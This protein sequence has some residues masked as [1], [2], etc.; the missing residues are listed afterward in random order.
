MN[1]NNTILD[2]IITIGKVG[3]V[4]IA[5]YFSK[6]YVQRSRKND[7]TKAGIIEKLV[8]YISAL[9]IIA[10]CSWAI[11]EFEGFNL[12]IF[13]I[14]SVAS[15]YGLFIEFGKDARLT[16]EQRLKRNMQIKHEDFINKKYENEY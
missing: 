7:E 3:V 9:C 16:P 5:F 13:V 4:L 11:T 15:I 1:W 14:V 2:A 6:F 8:V 12:G 10:F